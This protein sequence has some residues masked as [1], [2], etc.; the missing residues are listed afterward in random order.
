MP[1]VGM[2]KNGENIKPQSKETLFK[3]FK[4]FKRLKLLE[5]SFRQW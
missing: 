3:L 2:R 1:E 4:L 5:P